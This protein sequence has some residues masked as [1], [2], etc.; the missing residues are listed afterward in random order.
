[1]TGS[2]FRY[3]LFA[4]ALFPL[5]MAA[6]SPSRYNVAWEGPSPSSAGSMPL[7]NGD[8]G[9][10]VWVEPAGDVLFYIS[11]TDAWNA[12][13]TEGDLVKLAR[14]RVSLDPP[15]SAETARQELSLADG[16][17]QISGRMGSTNGAVRIWVDANRPVIWVESSSTDP[18]GISATVELWRSGEQCALRFQTNR[19]AFYHS[20]RWSRV[21]IPKGGPD[22]LTG[23]HFG[24]ILKGGGMIVDGENSLALK[25]QSP[26]ASRAMTISVLALQT[27]TPDEFDAALDACDATNTVVA[28]AEAWTAHARWW[29]AFWER[30]WIHI[31]GRERDDDAFAVA[32]GY[33]LQR[34]MS[35]CAG[36]GAYP[37]KFNGSIFT[38]DIDRFDAK[39]IWLLSADTRLWGPAYWFQNT[40]LIYWPMLASGDFEMMT[41]LFGF[42]ESLTPRLRELCQTKYK[43]AGAEF[44]ET[45]SAWGQE[46][47]GPWTE[48]DWNGALELLAMILDHYA[49]TGDRHDLEAWLVPLGQAYLDFFDL[50]FQRENGKLKMTPSH[51][52]ETYFDVVNPTP[53]VAGLHRVLDGLLALPAADLP[54]EFRK[55]CERM[56]TE[57]P[58]IPVVNVDWAARFRSDDGKKF[59]FPSQAKPG[60]RCLAPAEVI[61]DKNP[62]NSENSELYAIFPFRQFG[63]GRPDLDVA[64]E[65]Y[66]RRLFTMNNCWG[67]VEIHAASVGLGDEAWRGLVQRGKA[68]NALCRFPAF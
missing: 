33:A 12:W 47:G 61:L 54:A 30:S 22:M 3:A 35:A 18:L 65:S 32:R 31:G 55:Q 9:L 51:A 37:I 59:P 21:S 28:K 6:Q 23:R 46:K 63:I 67:Q 8:I 36:R 13:N 64:V 14:V 27:K 2:P 1:M 66:W 41:P 49:Y 26:S 20:P 34:F 17:I 57:L 68:H 19:V 60:A 7:G 42:Y 5:A 43:H 56:R 4:A 48:R 11:K 58:P 62:H 45:I 25:S 52:N 53:D 10:N 39:R 15:L 38:M 29:K 24:G 50:H 44:Q 40:R 16:S